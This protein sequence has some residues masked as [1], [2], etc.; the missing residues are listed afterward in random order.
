M[1][2]RHEPRLGTDSRLRRYDDLIDMIGDPASPTPI[3]ALRH[4]VAGD[5]LTLYVKLEWMNPFGSIKDRAAKWM[6]SA[7]EQRGELR[8]K[9]I[10]EPTSGNTGIA[11]AAMATL[12]DIPMSVTVPRDLSPEKYAI[13][14]MLGAEVVRTPDAPDS[15][16]HPMD[17]AIEMAE[18]MVATSDD[19]VMPDQYDNPDNTRAHYESTGPEIWE[20][21]QGRIRYFFAGFGTCGTLVGTGR[22]LKERDPGV[23]VIAIEPV[24]GHHISGLKNMEETAVPG[25][26]DRSVIDEVVSVDDEMTRSTIRRLY[27][28]E[29]LMVGPSGAAIIAGAMRY[30]EGREGIAVAIAPDTGQKA[31]SY[32]IDTMRG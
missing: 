24:P 9:G 18:D 6:L 1:A 16:R 32:L 31:A 20:Q 7:L 14:C 30:L 12:M 21:T 28:E 3:V 27:R 15:G 4:M 8:D 23:Q 26:L 17:V 10:V 5:A 22:Y 13:L 25:I 11:L 29:A 2:D 19:L